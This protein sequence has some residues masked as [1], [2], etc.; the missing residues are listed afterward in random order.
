MRKIFAWACRR[1]LPIR[2]RAAAMIASSEP[3]Q[4]HPAQSGGGWDKNALDVQ[5]QP[6]KG[7]LEAGPIL[8][9]QHLL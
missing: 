1:L 2:V 3:P 6:V 5:A 9:P 7:G 4:V 8:L